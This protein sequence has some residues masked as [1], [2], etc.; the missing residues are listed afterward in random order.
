MR[1]NE[2]DIT[3]EYNSQKKEP[4]GLHITTSHTQ[5]HIKNMLYDHYLVLC[6][7]NNIITGNRYT[8]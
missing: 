2:D 5:A 1:L 6:S 4:C 8:V 3:C 7:N